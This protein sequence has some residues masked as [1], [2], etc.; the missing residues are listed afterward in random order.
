[1]LIVEFM[2]LSVLCFSV[3]YRKS[4]EGKSYSWLTECDKSDTVIRSR[5]LQ[6]SNLWYLGTQPGAIGRFEI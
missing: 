3:H 1:M 6:I 2:Q 4:M 5:V